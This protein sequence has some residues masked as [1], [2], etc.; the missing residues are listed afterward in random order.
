MRAIASICLFVCWCIERMYVFMSWGGG[1]E[2]DM[3]MAKE[4]CEEAMLLLK[5]GMEVV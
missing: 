2:L 3:L 5:R 4:S 1:G